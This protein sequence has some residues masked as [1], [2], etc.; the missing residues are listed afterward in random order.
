MY[1]CIDM[2]VQCDCAHLRRLARA[3]THTHSH[4]GTDLK[5]FIDLTLHCLLP[6][7]RSLCILA[8]PVFFFFL[9]YICDLRLLFFNTSGILFFLCT[10]NVFLI[11]PC[12]VCP[13][14]SLDIFAWKR[15]CVFSCA[16]AHVFTHFVTVIDQLGTGVCVN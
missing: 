6:Y 4:I 1:V 12:F 7:C 13:L 11:Y 2:I 9:R 16:C 10:G 8:D 14:A 15:M 5:K 3:S